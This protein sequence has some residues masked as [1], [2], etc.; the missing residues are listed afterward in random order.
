MRS[1]PENGEGCYL[2]KG[3]PNKDGFEEPFLG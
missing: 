1:I 3:Y 2:L